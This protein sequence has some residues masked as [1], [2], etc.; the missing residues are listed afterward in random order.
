MAAC[1]WCGES[2]KTDYCSENCRVNDME[3]AIDPEKRIE[4]QQKF[5]AWLDAKERELE[6]NSKGG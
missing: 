4:L 5:D 6:E 1:K 2:C 3:A